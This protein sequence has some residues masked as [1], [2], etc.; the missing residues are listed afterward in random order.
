MSDS[1]YPLSLLCIYNGAFYRWDWTQNLSIIA[2]FQPYK[3]IIFPSQKMGKRERVY[4]LIK[5]HLSNGRRTIAVSV[6]EKKEKVCVCLY[7]NGLRTIAIGHLIDLVDWKIMCSENF[8]QCKLNFFLPQ[9]MALL[10]V[11]LHFS[12]CNKRTSLKV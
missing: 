5:R 3:I 11:Y 2:D 1:R 10:N 7:S 9:G 4:S 8:L 12:C 6:Q